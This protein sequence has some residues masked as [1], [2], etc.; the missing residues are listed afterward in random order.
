MY[1]KSLFETTVGWTAGGAAA[2]LTVAQ[3]TGQDLLSGRV[4]AGVGV[5]AV[6][7]LIKGLASKYGGNPDSSTLTS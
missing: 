2:A 5:A 1:L 7:G 3:T 4:W 6:V